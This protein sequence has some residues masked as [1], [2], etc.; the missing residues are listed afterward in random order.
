MQQRSKREPKRATQEACDSPSVIMGSTKVWCCIDGV[1][2]RILAITTECMCG[3]L[4][5]LLCA[6]PFYLAGSIQTGS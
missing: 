1:S 6:I 4:S 3:F 2:A 5:G